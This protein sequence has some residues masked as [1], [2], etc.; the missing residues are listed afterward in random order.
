MKKP[1]KL[2]RDEKATA[3]AAATRR[4][5]EQA[6]YDDGWHMRAVLRQADPQWLAAAFHDG[7]AAVG[8]AL[9]D[10]Y[11]QGWFDCEANRRLEW[12]LER[13]QHEDQIAE[14]W[15]NVFGVEQD[16]A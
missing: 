4:S 5:S 14:I 10:H 9:S 1:T 7:R 3:T 12:A 6:A 15:E 13:L 16:E 8:E 2:T 11:C